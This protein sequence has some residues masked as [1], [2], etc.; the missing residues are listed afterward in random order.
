MTITT[1]SIELQ[2]SIMEKELPALSKM[3]MDFG[4]IEQPL[5]AVLRKGKDH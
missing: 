1:S 3:L 2:K 5:T 4:L